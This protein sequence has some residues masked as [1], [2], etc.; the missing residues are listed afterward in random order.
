MRSATTC[1]PSASATRIS[2]D[3]ATRRRRPGPR[4]RRQL[5]PPKWDELF[6]VPPPIPPA[7]PDEPASAPPE[8]PPSKPPEPRWT[9]TQ[10]PHELR[11][12][13]VLC[14]VDMV[15]RCPL[16]HGG[17]YR[18]VDE[19]HVSAKP[20]L[21]ECERTFR[22]RPYKREPPDRRAALRLRRALADARLWRPCE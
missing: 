5:R 8:S 11:E 19:G 10:L 9:E 18:R 4:T 7:P 15:L 16:G 1:E 6:I 22:Y 17:V 2:R 12:L 14:I 21:D 20:T 3:M 13:L